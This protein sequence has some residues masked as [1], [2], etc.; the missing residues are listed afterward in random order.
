M[1]DIHCNSG[2]TEI[3][4]LDVIDAAIVIAAKPPSMTIFYRNET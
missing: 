2:R 3:R 1:G 4:Q